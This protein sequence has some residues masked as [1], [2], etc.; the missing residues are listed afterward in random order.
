MQE[1]RIIEYR[2]RG[3]S[4]VDSIGAEI[5]FDPAGNISSNLTEADYKQ[6][7]LRFK[8][9]GKSAIP[10]IQYDGRD[11]DELCVAFQAETADHNYIDFNVQILADALTYYCRCQGQL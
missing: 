9:C 3:I 5:T 6:G 2:G 7:V 11:D 1:T 10:V 4:L 8:R